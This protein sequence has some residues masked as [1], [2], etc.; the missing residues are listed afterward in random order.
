MGYIVHM[1]V[2]NISG[3]CDKHGPWVVVFCVWWSPLPYI[4]RSV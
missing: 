2:R 3:D 4:R 1:C